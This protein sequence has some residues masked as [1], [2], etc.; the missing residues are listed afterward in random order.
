MSL[1]LCS[2]DEFGCLYDIESLFEENEEKCLKQCTGTRVTNY[3][4]EEV[5]DKEK[6]KQLK[7]KESQS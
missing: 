7:K 3:V 1:P 4:K 2:P 6:Y 5:N